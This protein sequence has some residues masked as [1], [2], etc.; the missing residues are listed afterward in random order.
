MFLVHNAIVIFDLAS[1]KSTISKNVRPHCSDHHSE[2]KRNYNVVEIWECDYDQLAKSK[3]FKQFKKEFNKEIIT[4]LIPREA[5]YGGRTNATKL[6][7]KAKHGEKLKYIDFVSLYPTVMYYDY[8]PVGHPTVILDPKEYDE[9]WFGLI[10]CKILPP[11]NLYHPVLPAKIKLKNNKKL[12]FTL[13]YKCAKY[14]Q[15]RCNHSSEDRALIGTWCTNEIQKAI[16]KGYKII[17][18][19]EVHHFDK[20]SNELFKS[21]IKRFM[22]IKQ[23]SSGLPKIIQKNNILKKIMNNLE[24]Y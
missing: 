5:F 9:N 1:R 20:K 22:K 17:K 16:E 15:K 10:K 11:D 24:L 2:Y 12:L 8:Y 21:Y 4:K 18:I 6:Y 13:C 23:E 14:Q 19:Y 7:Y 3:G